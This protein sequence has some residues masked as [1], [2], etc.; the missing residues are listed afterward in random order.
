MGWEL[1]A[2]ITEEK[3][4]GTP[5]RDERRNLGIFLVMNLFRVKHSSGDNG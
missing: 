2:D 3:S 1:I 5:A 4:D